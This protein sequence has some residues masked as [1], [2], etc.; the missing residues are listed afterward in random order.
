MIALD[1][2]SYD[3]LHYTAPNGQRM[4][5]AEACFANAYRGHV[6]VLTDA[7]PG[8]IACDRDQGWAPYVGM[9]IVISDFSNEGFNGITMSGDV[10]MADES[11]PAHGKHVWSVPVNSFRIFERDPRQAKRLTVPTSKIRKD[12]V[13]LT[14]GMRIRIPGERRTR[15]GG[16]GTT[17]YAWS[18]IVENLE[19]VLKEGLVPRSFLCEDIWVE[20]KGWDCRLTGQWTIQGN[21]FARWTVERY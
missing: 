18:G 3:H 17:V 10:H 21:D 8:H 11:H 7:R 2:A 13:V 5:G 20:G 6:A 14:Y 16:H 19:E 1:R 4:T 9:Q 12:D 15:D